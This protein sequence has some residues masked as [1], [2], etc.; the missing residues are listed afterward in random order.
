M[1]KKKKKIFKKKSSKR[2]QNP[3]TYCNSI[4]NLK[5]QHEPKMSSSKNP[6]IKIIDLN[7]LRAKIH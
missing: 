5:F 7:Y 6:H 1:Q 2:N 4:T 3:S